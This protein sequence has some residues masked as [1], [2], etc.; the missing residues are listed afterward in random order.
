VLT[1]S[2][3]WDVLVLIG[4]LLGAF[5][6]ARSAAGFRIRIMPDSQWVAAFGPSVAK[7]WVFAFAGAL[8]TQFGAGIAG[9]CT[10]SLAMSGGAA[11]SPAAFVF[12]AGRFAGGMATAWL[13]Y[14]RVRHA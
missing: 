10:A 5:L 12:M 8:L 14:W 13:V 4:A 7:R 11:L 1:G 2:G 3:R 6:A 9:G